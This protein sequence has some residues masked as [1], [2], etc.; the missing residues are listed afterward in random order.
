M[1][2]LIPVLFLGLFLAGCGSNGHD[3]KSLAPHPGD[4]VIYVFRPDYG[5]GNSG[6][7]KIMVDDEKIGSL[8]NN[9]YLYK[10][11]SPGQHVVSSKTETTS[12]VPFEA[13]AGQSYYI[14]ADRVFGFWVA[15]PR[16]MMMSQDDGAAAI[17]SS[18]YYDKEDPEFIP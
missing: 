16:L 12:K 13:Q 14:R 9:T 1:R 15:R 6:S 5:Y 3:F 2:K 11:I 10:R 17:L 8:K 18:A 7:L 4:S